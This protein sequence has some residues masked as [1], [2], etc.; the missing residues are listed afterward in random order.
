M[1]IGGLI[2]AIALAVGIIFLKVT[3][4]PVE[5]WAS[6]QSQTRLEKDYFDENFNPFYRTTQVII[7]AENRSEV[8]GQT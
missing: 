3:I 6:P 7:H 5:L 1:L 4:D 8:S 2:V